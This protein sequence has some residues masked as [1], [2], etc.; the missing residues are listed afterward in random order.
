[1]EKER[2]IKSLINTAKDS[3]KAESY[4]SA[5]AILLMIPEIINGKNDEEAYIFWCD[6]YIKKFSD[7]S[8]EVLYKLKKELFFGN[9]K[10]NSYCTPNIKV[11]PVVGDKTRFS[12]DTRDEDRNWRTY[13]ADI[14]DFMN[15]MIDS[16]ESYLL[17]GVA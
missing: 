7:F 3:I 10:N 17:V 14:N 1:M 13:S 11:Y 12:F 2:V 9:K 5:F 8:G 16:I 6:R 15:N 4:Y